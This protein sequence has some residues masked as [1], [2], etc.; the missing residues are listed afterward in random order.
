MKEDL[1]D[2][3]IQDRLRKSGSKKGAE[4]KVKK[5]FRDYFRKNKA[6]IS[7]WQQL[8]QIYDLLS[9]KRITRQDRALVIGGLLY[10]INPFDVVPDMVPLVGFL[11]D[12]AI[13]ALVYRYLTNRAQEDSESLS[14]S[15]FPMDNSKKSN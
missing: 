6:K 12:M 14:K 13:I 8:E 10:F 2:Q 5:K 4:E 3:E 7:F 15:D 11:D 1:S 9:S